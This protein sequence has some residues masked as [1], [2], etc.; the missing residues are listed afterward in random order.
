MTEK[1]P[2]SD[3]TENK[4]SSR[5]TPTWEMELLISGATVFGLMQL[6]APLSR[7]TA[8]LMNSNTELIASLISIVSIYLYVSLIVLIV[9]FILHLIA[10]G[11]WVAMVGLDSVYPQGIKWDKISSF[12]PAHRSVTEESTRPM[13]QLIEQADNRATVI[14][15]LGFGLAVSLLIPIFIVGSMLLVLLVVQ[16]FGADIALWHAL[17]WLLFFILLG[18]WIAAY[19]GDYYWGE[20]LARAGKDGWLKSVFR[21]Y[22]KIGFGSG[23]N[24]VVS[25]YTTNRGSKKMGMLL[26]GGGVLF[27]FA[28]IMALDSRGLA[29]D[30]GAF[31]G[32]P[33]TLAA[34]TPTIRPENYR[35][36]R[37]DGQS[38]LLVPTIEDVVADESYLRLFIPYQPSKY[39]SLIRK[40]CPA[41][42]TAASANKGAG[43]ACLSKV[44]DI[45]MDGKPVAVPLMASV[46]VD[47]RQ[48]GMVAM[49]DVRKLGEGQHELSMIVF[50]RNIE[51]RAESRVHRIPFWK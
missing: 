38:L 51:S 44:F 4:L 35:Q 29:L 23:N 16:Y 19:I 37:T 43:M 30:N 2:E 48:R 24:T 45:R 3:E 36:L 33:R 25:L 22:Q 39:N 31:P 6:P 20:K 41:A 8:L 13:K 17:L 42:L 10:R 14:F 47:T 46:D 21:A 28:A 26:V 11:Y 5:T 12:G 15:G 34:D 7:A 1:M 50:P 49:I 18:P 32:L 40:Q 27:S 9:A